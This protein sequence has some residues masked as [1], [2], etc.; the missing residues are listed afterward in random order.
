M[1]LSSRANGVTPAELNKLTEWKGAL[2]KWLFQNPKRTG[3]C[4]R[5]G[6]SFEVIKGDKGTH[7]KTTKTV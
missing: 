5:W 4:D 6:Y 2:W 3:Y 1:K 7:Y